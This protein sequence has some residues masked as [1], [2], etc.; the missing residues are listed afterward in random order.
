VRRRNFKSTVPFLRLPMAFVHGKCP[1]WKALSGR[2]KLLYIYLKGCY[3]GSNNGEITLHYRQL[4]GHRGISSS[5]AI[6]NGL[7]EL[8]KGEWIERV[9]L[10]GLYRKINKYRLTWKYDLCHSDPVTRD[11]KDK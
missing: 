9:Q 6:S 10:G 5:S 7:R 8:E 4:K 3:N 1:E 11:P 2:A